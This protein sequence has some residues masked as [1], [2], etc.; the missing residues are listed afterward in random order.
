VLS[1]SGTL[2]AGRDACEYVTYPPQVSACATW[3]SSYP[4]AAWL[5]LPGPY[6]SAAIIRPFDVGRSFCRLLATCLAPPLRRRGRIVTPT[7]VR[8]IWS[9]SA[10]PVHA[11][12]IG[13]H[14]DQDEE[15]ARV[16]RFAALSPIRT[17]ARRSTSTGAHLERPGRPAGGIR[18]P[19]KAA[20]SPHAPAPPGGP[21]A[22]RR[23]G[24]GPG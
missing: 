24:P 10:A 13:N 8:F 18:R 11:V 21:R 9:G 3:D 22:V 20:P 15:R 14:V 23:R 4:V 12:E 19:P 1:L 17:N 5:W 16:R 7:P 6:Q 2:L